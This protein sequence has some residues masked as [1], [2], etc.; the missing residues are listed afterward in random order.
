MTRVVP[1][2][3]VLVSSLL[4]PLGNAAAIIRLF[5]ENKLDFVLS[6]KI[7]AEVERVLRYPKIKKRTGW[8]AK[9]NKEFCVK[10]AKFCI[11]TED[12][13]EKGII[14]EDPADDKFL[15]C[16]VKGNADY[17][18]T[19]DVHLLKLQHFKGVDIVTPKE[20]LEKMI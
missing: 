6:D 5:R 16:A 9:E 14:S 15:F 2:T 1:D 3:N 19:G 4:S 11:I 10:L 13:E 17:I 8:S 18:I 7:L 20:F 12:T